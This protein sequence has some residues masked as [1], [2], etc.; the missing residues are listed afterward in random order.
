LRT[1]MRP[2]ADAARPT[3]HPTALAQANWFRARAS[4]SVSSPGSREAA[5]L[6]PN[7]WTVWLKWTELPPDRA[8]AEFC[9]FRPFCPRA[10]GFIS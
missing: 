6:P 8:A 10:R 9:P 3:A 4:A 5:P 1:A 2:F 7:S